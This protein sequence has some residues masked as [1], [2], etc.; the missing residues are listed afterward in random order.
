MGKISCNTQRLSVVTSSL[1]GI[2]FGCAIIYIITRMVAIQRRLMYLET[3][4]VKKADDDMMETL[5]SRV[6]S[7]QSCTQ[8]MLS[9]MSNAIG[10]VIGY[11]NHGEERVVEERVVEER[12]G[13][14]IPSCYTVDDGSR[15]PVQ[16]PRDSKL[17]EDMPSPDQN[18]TPVLEESEELSEE[19]VEVCEVE[20]CEAEECEA[21][22]CEAEECEV[23]VCEVEECEVEVCEV[24][25]C[26]AEELVE[27]CEVESVPHPRVV[28]DVDDDAVHLNM[29]MKTEPGY[30]NK[31]E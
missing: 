12:V 16:P 7:I 5:S 6:D 23:E 9:G 14:M 27:V 26:E 18:M 30:K 21:E 19:L 15:P 13:Q 22:E 24:E 8:N 11:D 25:V 20:V 2:I 10:E 28:I 3:H 17:M 1:M 4:I 31:M 29:A